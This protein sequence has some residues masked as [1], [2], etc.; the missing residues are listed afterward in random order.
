MS[1]SSARAES[2]ARADRGLKRPA[3]EFE[4]GLRQTVAWY[5]EH[6]D[7]V[8]TIRTGAYLKYYEQQYGSR[9]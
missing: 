7:W 5:R 8:A 2:S 6:A 4:E 1:M 9:S 3:V